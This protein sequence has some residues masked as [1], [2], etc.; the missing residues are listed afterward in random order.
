M[1]NI[2]LA[3]KSRKISRRRCLQV[4]T[5]GLGGVSLADVLAAKAMASPDTSFI[6]VQ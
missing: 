1:L 3:D 4:G 5:L 2:N 6:P